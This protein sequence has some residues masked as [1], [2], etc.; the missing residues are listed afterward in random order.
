MVGRYI[1]EQYNHLWLVA[2]W[3]E[4]SLARLEEALQSMCLAWLA[5]GTMST[6]MPCSRALFFREVS[7]GGCYLTLGEV[8]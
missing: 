7:C 1:G 4:M 2:L 6:N 3:N 8:V 5:I